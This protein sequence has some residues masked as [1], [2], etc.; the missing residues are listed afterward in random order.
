MFAKLKWLFK[1]WFLSKKE[2]ELMK[3]HIF[4][5]QTQFKYLQQRLDRMEVPR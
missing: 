2:R 5:L 3:Q 1:E 4:H